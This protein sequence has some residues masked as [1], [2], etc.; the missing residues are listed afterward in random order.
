LGV[1]L[2]AAQ[3]LVRH[4][5]RQKSDWLMPQYAPEICNNSCA[6]TQSKYTLLLH[7]RTHMFRH[8]FIDRLKACG[9]IPAAIA[10]A[11]T[12]HER[13]ASEFARYDSVGYTL[14]QKSP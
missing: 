13:N 9:D 14:K 12:G 8:D 11:I 3:E 2:K 6:D 1:L 4:A 5:V 10:E 7:F